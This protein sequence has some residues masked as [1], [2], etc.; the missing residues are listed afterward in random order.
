VKTALRWGT[1]SR[2]SD[3][4]TDIYS[5]AAFETDGADFPG[6]DG[7][8]LLARATDHGNALGV[9]AWNGKHGDGCRRTAVR[10][11]MPATVED[12]IPALAQWISE[13]SSAGGNKSA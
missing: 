13:K 1:N 4:V 2:R 12:A 6:I 3:N 5:V 11:K 9:A 8:R 7:W 10:M